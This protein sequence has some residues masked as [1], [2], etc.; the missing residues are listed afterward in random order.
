MAR[1]DIAL[2]GGFGARLDGQPV[3]G[4]VSTKARA[5][6]A[7]LATEADRPHQREELA[8]LLWPEC[9][10]P[11]ARRSLSQAL[12]NLRSILG[13]RDLPGTPGHTRASS[14]ESSAG[15]PVC[16]IPFLLVRSETIQCNPASDQHADVTLFTSLL[17]AS[18]E[19][20]HHAGEECEAC[21]RRLA[22][23]VDLYRGDL[24]QDLAIGDSAPFEEWAAV[25]R[26]QLHRQALDALQRLAAAHGRRG[27]YA[28]GLSY[29]WRQVELD[30]WREEGQRHLMHLL[31]LAGQRGAAL[32]Q[33]ETCR[34]ALAEELGA[35]PAAETTALYDQ[36]REGS[37]F[38]VRPLGR[39]WREDGP[40]GRTTNED[41][42]APAREDRPDDGQQS[43]PLAANEDWRIFQSPRP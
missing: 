9:S 40:D 39:S 4:F 10:T 41:R 34:K 8:A 5:L 17:Q 25:R 12:F 6:L 18:A 30:P 37:L 22:E 43:W 1:L 11:K 15:L 35:E 26:E 38:V 42:R 13:D 20:A 2:L 16:S 29:A 24:M 28:R 21:L 14:D 32:A 36:I 7:Y 23:A 3:E 33:Y 31:A 19:H 27:D